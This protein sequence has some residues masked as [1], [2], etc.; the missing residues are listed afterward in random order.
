[1]TQRGAHRMLI[2]QMS[3]LSRGRTEAKRQLRII[4][5]C[6]YCA[7]GLAA[8][9]VIPRNVQSPLASFDGSQ[10]NS[11]FIGFASNGQGIISEHGRQHYDALIEQYGAR[12]EVPLRADEGL[13]LTASNTWIIDQEHLIK[14][15][16]MQWW[17]N[18]EK[19]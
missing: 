19:G 7:A 9:T 1:M 16:H 10:E 4:F 11:G 12:Y 2:R 17:R 18:Q 14:Y 3:L 8:C 15:Q 5:A 6:G 13:R